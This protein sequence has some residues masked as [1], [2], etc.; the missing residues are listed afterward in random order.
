[1]TCQ[2]PRGAA[3]W[4]ILPLSVDAAAGSSHGSLAAQTKRIASHPRRK[5]GYSV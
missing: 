1:M 5:V 4:I 2:S 3:R